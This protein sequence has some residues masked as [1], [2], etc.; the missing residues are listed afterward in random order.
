MSKIIVSA[1]LAD[2]MDTHEYVANSIIEEFSDAIYENLEKTGMSE[3]ELAKKAKLCQFT[4]SQFKKGNQ[5][6][7]ISTVAKICHALEMIPVITFK[8]R[9][10]IPIEGNP[11]YEDMTKILE[12]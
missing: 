4:I 2:I 1:W 10:F 8:S 6:I 7:S 12:E 5:R 11:T 3:K 9:E